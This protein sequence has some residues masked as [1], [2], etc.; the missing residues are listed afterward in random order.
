LP[1]IIP[2]RSQ[3]GKSV[4][5]VPPT[6]AAAAATTTTTKPKTIPFVSSHPL[7]IRFRA[8]FQP[9][10]L[11][12]PTPAAREVHSHPAALLPLLLPSPITPY[13][14]HSF[15]RTWCIYILYVWREASAI[16]EPS[17]SKR[18]YNTSAC[19]VQIV[20]GRGCG[21]GLVYIYNIIYILHNAP[22]FVSK[23]PKRPVYIYVL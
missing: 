3:R 23:T 4:G 18:P 22:K 17:S 7:C 2:A 19:S 15:T 6:N 21:S 11:S 5:R 13:T 9:L 16:I 14:N 1:N 10:N 20:L 12:R 8:N